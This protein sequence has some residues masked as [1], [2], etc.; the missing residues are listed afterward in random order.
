MINLDNI[1]I[2]LHALLAD[3]KDKAMSAK[4]SSEKAWSE[5]FVLKQDENSE[6]EDIRRA[7][8]SYRE[9][10]GELYVYRRIYKDIRARMLAE[11]IP[12][13]D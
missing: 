4:E 9:Y 6:M 10:Q 11:V 7:F 2:D 1:K 13:L 8:G 3:Y 12:E 5:Y